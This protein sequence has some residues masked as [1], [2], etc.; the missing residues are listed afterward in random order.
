[1]ALG[2]FYEEMPD[3]VDELVET[4]QGVY[5]IVQD[6]P[7]EKGIKMPND[8]IKFVVGLGDYVDTNRKAVSDRTEIQNLIDEI[9]QLIDTTAYK[10]KN[11]S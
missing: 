9:T 4:Y 11:L 7:F 5:G 10:L 8:P 6:Y 2:T 3:K 1:M